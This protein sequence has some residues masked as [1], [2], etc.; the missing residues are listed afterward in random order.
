MKNIYWGWNTS[1]ETIVIVVN[2]KNHPLPRGGCNGKEGRRRGRG[3]GGR[4]GGVDAMGR[5]VGG[6]G[7]VR[8]KGG[9]EG[10]EEE[11]GCNGKDSKSAYS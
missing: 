1:F 11:G 5:K 2:I 10:R 3:G 4:R 9:W 6:G 8:R 7:G